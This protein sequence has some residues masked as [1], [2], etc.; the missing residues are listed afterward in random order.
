MHA[1]IHAH[2]HAYIH[3]FVQQNIRDIHK[4]DTQRILYSIYIYYVYILCACYAYITYKISLCKY[5]CIL[6]ICDVICVR[7]MHILCV[8]IYMYMYT[9][10][11]WPR[12]GPWDHKYLKD[13]WDPK[14]GVGS[15]SAMVASVVR[16]PRMRWTQSRNFAT[17]IPSEPSI[18]PIKKK[19]GN[20]AV[21]FI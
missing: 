18:H 19:Q 6:C 7:I 12:K 4:K 5:K 17:E 21:F 3:E 9:R 14:D 8:C 1:H 15:P 10:D 16:S 13:P 11:P 2:R 20:S